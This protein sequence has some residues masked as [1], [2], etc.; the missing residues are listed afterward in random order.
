[1]I[2]MVAVLAICVDGGLLF[3]QRRAVQ[4][5]ADAASLAGA[6]DLYANYQA[7]NGQDSKG[8]ARA[9]ALATAAANGCTNDGTNS[10]VTVNIPPASGSFKGQAGYVEVIVQ[11]NVQRLF[12]IVLGTGSVPVSGRAVARGRWASYQ[13]AIMTLDPT[14]SGSLAGTGNATAVT[15]AKIIIDSNSGSSITANGNVSMTSP[16]FDLVGGTSAGSYLHGQVVNISTPVPDPLAYLPSPDPSTMPVQSGGNVSGNKTVTLTPGLYPGGIRI[17][18]NARVTLMPGIYYMQGGGISTSGNG[19]LTGSG[20]MIY[21]DGGGAIDLSGN[22]AVNLSPPTSGTY[23]GITI[24][25]ART[26]STAMSISGN[27]NMTITGTFYAPKAPVTITGNGSSNAIGSQYIAYDLSLNGNGSINV[28]WSQNT[29]ARAR[30][31][32]LV[33]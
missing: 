19:S 3:D 8:T 28:S 16:E 7:N 20:V 9:S 33:E 22:G 10:I 15:G 18:G 30:W 1:M 12:S 17:Q 27:G 32:Q 29:T 6:S 26:S 21:N 25:Q 2:A 23:T 31:V 5:V 11:E 4:S 24:F 13:A 14:G